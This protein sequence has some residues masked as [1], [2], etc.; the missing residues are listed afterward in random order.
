LAS[1]GYV[2]LEDYNMIMQVTAI[3][4]RRSPV[5]VILDKSHRRIRRD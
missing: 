1:N 4:H 5:S 2:A 3:T